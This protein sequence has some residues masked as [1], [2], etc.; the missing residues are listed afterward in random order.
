MNAPEL[1]S[2][3]GDHLA[4]SAGAKLNLP[5]VVENLDELVGTL[6]G[7]GA[8]LSDGIVCRALNGEVLYVSPVILS[9]SGLTLE[10]FKAAHP[11]SASDESSVVVSRTPARP[12]DAAAMPAPQVLAGLS[13]AQVRR[14]DGRVADVE[15]DLT[16]VLDRSGTPVATITLARDVTAQRRQGELERLSANAIR[17]LLDLVPIGIG[18]RTVAPPGDIIFANRAA[19]RIAGCEPG[20]LIGRPVFD[21][22]HPDDHAFLLQRMTT[23]THEGLDSSEY[24]IRTQ[25]GVTKWMRSA[26]SRLIWDGEEA[27][28]ISLQDV[29]PQKDELLQAAHDLHD[30]V[31]Q[32]AVA[33]NMRLSL[34]V[35]E[36]GNVDLDSAWIARDIITDIVGNASG[37]LSRLE[38][39]LEP[40]LSDSP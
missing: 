36:L 29:T 26:T 19:E 34:S 1:P 25:D 23:A 31:L 10:Q 35:G 12:L 7:I 9:S 38:S 18:V 20:W 13:T 33:S 8:L 2:S 16:S 37:L 14:P 32:P 11:H 22:I 17:Q 21:I 15:F 4:T 3:T 40:R 39:A 27:I 5:V 6:E 30:Q 24:R 28:L